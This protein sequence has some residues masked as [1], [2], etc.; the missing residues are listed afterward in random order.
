MKAT[1]TKVHI[2]AP[3]ESMELVIKECLPLFLDLDITYSIGD[4]S[5]GVE[6]AILEEKKGT[7]V[8]I[9]RGGT[10][11]LIKKAVHIPVIDM[12]LSGYDMIRSLTLASNLKDK[13]AI[14]GFSN[15]TSGAQSI[16]DLLDL[17]LKVFTVSDS[18]EVAPLLLKLKNSGFKQIVGDVITMKTSNAYG[19]NGFLIQSGKES[20]IK[21]LED[22]KL[23]TGYLSNKTK[24]IEVF[25]RFIVRDANNI[26]IVDDENHIIY[27]HFTDF[28]SN[29]L[30]E[31][32]LYMLNTDLL[33]NKNLINK[34]FSIDDCTIDVKGYYYN[35]IDK[36]YKIYTLEK[37]TINLL[38][39]K[40]LITHTDEMKEPIAIAST[41][42]SSIL[43]V[44]KLLY[45]NNE[46]VLLQG[47]KGTGKNFITTYIHKELSNDG[48][49]LTINFKNFNINTIEKLPLSKLSTVK[50]MN[51]AYIKDIEKFTNFLT[52]CKYSKVRIFIISEGPLDPDIM[53]DIKVNRIL[54]PNL[55]ERKDDISK[56]TQLFLS[57]YHQKYGTPAIKIK[58]EA[59]K[60]VEEQTYPNNIADLKELIK[61]IT[62]NEKDYVIHKETIEKVLSN[63]NISTELILSHKGTLKEIE[64]EIIQMVLEE[65]NQNQS[66]TAVRLGIN[67][68]TL[69]RKLKE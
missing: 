17:P 38:E 61:Q 59:L 62:L 39:Q 3:Y 66:K 57:Y 48:T 35:L 67:R 63:K 33:I 43:N 12:Q 11:Q 4:L 14:V 54:L 20:I 56:L 26:M 8:I 34:N 28:S 19:L 41:S 36:L 22:A 49:L 29:P 40:G 52:S 51:T 23:I 46:P 64:K 55:S 47:N 58:P 7:E 53:R 24:L 13:T 45:K 30:S 18:E 5:K 31:N 21:S 10:A 42:I 2:I 65:E 68:A 6:K 9:S 60:L 1:K 32:E 37:N 15:I 50:L 16:I 69:W 27:E 44:M 25:E